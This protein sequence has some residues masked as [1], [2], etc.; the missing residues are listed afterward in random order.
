MPLKAK[1][2]SS[3]RPLVFESGQCAR[4]C[5]PTFKSIVQRLTLTYL[6]PLA[7]NFTPGAWQHFGQFDDQRFTAQGLSI[8]DPSGTG[9]AAKLRGNFGIFA[10]VEQTLYRPPSVTEK[11]VSAS[12]PAVT[13]FGRIAYSPPDRN[14]IDLYLDGG[15]RHTVPSAVH[16]RA[17]T[18]N[19]ENNP[20]QSRVNPG[21]QHSCC[22]ASGREKKNAPSSWPQPNLIPL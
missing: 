4:G 1:G 15:T 9:I 11:G 6:R 22:A 5:H 21:S 2:F 12:L 10:V 14:L 18:K 16:G 17:W 8:A 7:G 13:A 20:M 3:R 19:R